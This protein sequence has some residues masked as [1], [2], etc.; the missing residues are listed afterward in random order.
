MAGVMQAVP[1]RHQRLRFSSCTPQPARRRRPDAADTGRGGHSFARRAGQHMGP[2]E[3]LIGIG[4]LAR[5]RSGTCDRHPRA[6]LTEARA[7]E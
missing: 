2:S 1:A 7:D 5:H 3:A 6:I 4:V